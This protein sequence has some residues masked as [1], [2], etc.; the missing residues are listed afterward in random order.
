M[1][2][3]TT[4]PTTRPVAGDAPLRGTGDL[5]DMRSIASQ[6]LGGRARL[7]YRWARFALQ[8][9]ASGDFDFVG[10]AL[11]SEV[12]LVGYAVQDALWRSDRVRCNLCGWHGNRF[13]PNTGPGYHERDTICP[14]CRC[15]DRHRALV[16]VLRH[17]TRFFE[18]GVPVVEVAPMMRFQEFTLA[19]KPTGYVS[20]DIE[21]FAMERGDITAM[22]YPDNSQ[23][24]FLALHVLEHIPDEARALSEIRRVLKPGGAAVLQ[25]PVDWSVPVGYEYARPDPREVGHVRRYGQDFGRHIA[26]HG[27]E[28]EPVGVGDFLDDRSIA[29]YGLSREPFFLARKPAAGAASR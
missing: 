16:A 18:D 29:R 15:Q 4:V 14:G 2:E 6:P 22:R 9:L 20:F 27:F 19:N 24:Y 5:E 1:H 26:T 23:D 28:V 3:A 7:A 17:S 25:V 13:Y 8:S 11:A 10:N 12:R 21:R